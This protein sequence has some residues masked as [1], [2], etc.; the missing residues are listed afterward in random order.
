MYY[1]NLCDELFNHSCKSIPLVN[2]RVNIILYFV[3]MT[4][5]NN[6]TLQLGRK[7]ESKNNSV[8]L[9]NKVNNCFGEE[10]IAN[11]WKSHFPN[12]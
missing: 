8:P 4:T 12:Y 11:M 3:S 10:N 9:A 1:N 7:L 5:S 2:S 6:S